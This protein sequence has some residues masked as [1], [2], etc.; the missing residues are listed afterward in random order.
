VAFGAHAVLAIREY[1]VRT[2]AGPLGGDPD[3]WGGT[4]PLARLLAIAGCALLVIGALKLTTRQAERPWVTVGWLLVVAA[5]LVLARG[6]L[7]L[8]LPGWD[9]RAEGATTSGF[10][11]TVLVDAV[12]VLGAIALAWF[13]A[14]KL[15][16]G[17]RTDPEL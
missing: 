3:P 17:S 6:P 1:N 14:E 2:T 16:G 7:A 8:G 13:S 5:V 12:I 10:G 4:L 9:A 15:V 11:G